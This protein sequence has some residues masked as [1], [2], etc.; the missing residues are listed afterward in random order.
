MSFIYF[1]LHRHL[2]GTH[3]T[4]VNLVFYPINR[5][6]RTDERT[7][8]EGRRTNEAYREMTSQSLNQDQPKPKREDVFEHCWISSTFFDRLSHDYCL[9]L[10][11]RISPKIYI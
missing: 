9:L 7:K 2:N 11:V 3:K 8:N 1:L 4:K 10:E 5:N 6:L